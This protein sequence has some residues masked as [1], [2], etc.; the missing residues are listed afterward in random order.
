[1]PAG[2]AAGISNGESDQQRRKLRRV[3]LADAFEVIVIS[4][5]CACAKPD[6]A[7]FRH[8]CERFGVSPANTLFI[9]DHYAIDA[10]GA[11]NAGLTGVWLDR[12]SVATAA[13]TPSILASLGDLPGLVERGGS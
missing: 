2:G 8:A 10:I 7:I 6:A 3:G 12:S 5:E 1:M 4:S 9:G 11:R 13:H